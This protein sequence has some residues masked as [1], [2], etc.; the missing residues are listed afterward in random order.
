MLTLLELQGT[1]SQALH[2]ALTTAPAREKTPYIE[3][4]FIALGLQ[5]RLAMAGLE[6]E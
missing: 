3:H 4:D 2:Q 6:S 5:T 1:L